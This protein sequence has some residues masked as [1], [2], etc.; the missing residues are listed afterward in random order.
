MRKEV[1]KSSRGDS[2]HFNASDNCAVISDKITGYAG[3]EIV[4]NL[5][6]RHVTRKV[7]MNRGH[8]DRTTNNLIDRPFVPI[9]RASGGPRESLGVSQ[10][11][12][13]ISRR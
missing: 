10:L 6:T 7:A 8:H 1:P 11:R 3:R 5:L 2:G 9:S 13:C 4:S 12:R